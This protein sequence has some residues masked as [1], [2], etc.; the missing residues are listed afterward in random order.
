LKYRAKL[1]ATTKIEK[2]KLSA[3]HEPPSIHAVVHKK[4]N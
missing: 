1:M 4:Y 2:A 3:V